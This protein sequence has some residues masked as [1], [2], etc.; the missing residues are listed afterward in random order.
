MKARKNIGSLIVVIVLAIV[1]LVQIIVPNK[2]NKP[3][4]VIAYDVISYYS[5]LPALFIEKDIKLS[6][7]KNEDPYKKRYW[8]ITTSEGDYMIKTTCGLSIMYSPFFAVAHILA[9]PLGYEPNGFTF[10]YTF[11]LLFSGVFFVI[12]GMIIL[13]KF[14]LRHFSDMVTLMAIAIIGLCTPLYWYATLESAMS[15]SYSFFLFSAFL[16]LTDLWYTDQKWKYVFAIGLIVGMISLVRP[17]NLL[18]VLVFLLY[19][20]TSFKQ[21]RERFFMFLHDYKKYLVMAILVIVVWIPQFIYWKVA[22]GHFVY[23]SY[24]DEGFYW[25]DPKIIECLFGFRK[26]LFLYSPILLCI[27]PGI[28]FLR[29]KCPQYFIPVIIF[30]ILNLYVISSWWCWWYGGGYS[31]RPMVESLALM[32][33]PLAAFIECF[34]SRKKVLKIVVAPVLCLMIFFSSFHIIQYYHEVIHYDAMSSKAYFESFLRLNRSDEYWN[35]L[36]C[37]DYDEARK[38]NR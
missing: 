31:M 36:D 25:L 23:Y 17:S 9:E 24:T 34:F 11:A 20:I 27:L 14:L 19:G 16:Y 3:E 12:L 22:T 6:F 13:R 30:S 32:A 38:G 4:R 1:Y 29:K 26:G 7:W 2:F 15:H 5:Y 35:L 21:V 33:I 28:W 10:P 18:V 8:P 37:P